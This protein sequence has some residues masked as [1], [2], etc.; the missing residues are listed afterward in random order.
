MQLAKMTEAQLHSGQVFSHYRILQKLGGG[1]MGVVYKAEDTRLD[2]KVAVKFLPDGIAQNEQALVRFRREAKAASALNHP[3]ICTVYDI[4]EENGRPFIVMEYLDGA[5]LKSLIGL[6]LM[7]LDQ[8]L[9]LSRGIADALAAAHNKNIIHRDIK[10]E[11]IFVC[12]G[13]HPKVLDFGLAKIHAPNEGRAESA[14]LSLTGE[15][16]AVGTLP[17]MSPEQLQGRSVDHRTDI[18]SLGAVVYEVAT[19]QRPF[20]GDTSAELTSSIL[21]D[22]PKPV[23]EL[24]PELPSGLHRIVARCLAKEPTERYVSALELRHALDLLRRQAS[25]GSLR[26]VA[27]IGAEA[28]IAVL[29]FTNLS[30]DQENEFFADGLTEEITTGLTQIEELRVAARR[31][32]FAFKGKH[33][34]LRIV[35]ERLNVKTVLEGSVRKAGNRVRIHAQ[36]VN[37]ADGYYLWSERYDREL[38]DIFEVQDDISRAITNRLRVDLFTLIGGAPT[39]SAVIDVFFRRV[40]ADESMNHFFT[41]ANLDRLRAHQNMFLSAL[42]GGPEPHTP[43][44]IRAAHAHLRPALNDI[45][46][47]TF[48]AH[49]RASLKE[50]GVKD[51]KLERVMKLIEGKR[52]AV[53]NR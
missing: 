6:P 37:I 41:G 25:S 33:V 53:L 18:F 10:P 14:T 23:T 4:G 49:F 50:V 44:D 51:D 17:Y 36:L 19:G 27:E 9:E 32:A 46:F 1:G 28:S 16:F 13:D 3:N 22:T 20:L 7:E 47:D 42:L 8:L 30:A 26:A 12:D 40:L 5:M 52:S 21:R 34:D 2:R 11:N 43:Q 29:P 48:L 24:R 38:K 39:V 31:S 35:G 45:H 15:G